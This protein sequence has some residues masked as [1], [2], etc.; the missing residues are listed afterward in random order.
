[1]KK[2]VILSGVAAFFLGACTLDRRRRP[3]IDRRFAGY[4]M[5]PGYGQLYPEHGY[6]V[7]RQLESG[8][9]HQKRC[10]MLP[11]RYFRDEQ[12]R[13]TLCARY[14]TRWLNPVKTVSPAPE[15]IA[16]AEKENVRDR[17]RA[18]CTSSGSL[19]KTVSR[20]R[21]IH[22]AKGRNLGLCE[23]VEMGDESVKPDSASTVRVLYKMTDRKGKDLQNTYD[24]KDTANPL[25]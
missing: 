20:Q 23:I 8:G 14:T 2:V 16:E 4:A 11:K 25:L 24:S 13:L 12:G 17:L 15:F 7:G 5:E 6:D 10:R 21:G 19:V 22:R 18:C 9:D 1:M 3:Q